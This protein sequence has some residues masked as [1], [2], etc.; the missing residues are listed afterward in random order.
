MLSFFRVRKFTVFLFSDKNY[1]DFF[2]IIITVTRK[3]EDDY[4][5]EMP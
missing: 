2:I 4:G 3:A 1:T 5:Y